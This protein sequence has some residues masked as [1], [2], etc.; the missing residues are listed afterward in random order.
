MWV[1]G[2]S[3]IASYL[4]LTSIDK[5]VK[6]ENCHHHV[7]WQQCCSK[8]KKGVDSVI[9]MNIKWN[10]TNKNL[11]LKIS[12]L[13]D[14]TL[15]CKSIELNDLAAK[16]SAKFCSL[17][18]FSHLVSR[19]NAFCHFQQVEHMCSSCQN[20]FQE[21]NHNFCIKFINNAHTRVIRVMIISWFSI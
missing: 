11:T 20:K 13:D 17:L 18:S 5:N 16:N 9:K 15:L 14:S 21:K 1:S 12:F 7:T 10:L 8:K 19:V 2:K 6:N 3:C 4:H